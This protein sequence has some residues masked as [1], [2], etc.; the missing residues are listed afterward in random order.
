[1]VTILDF[2]SNLFSNVNYS[3]VKIYISNRNLVYKCHTVTF[4]Q[5]NVCCNIWQQGAKIDQW[6]SSFPHF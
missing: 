5:F 3:N 1:M 4:D 2:Y 6:E